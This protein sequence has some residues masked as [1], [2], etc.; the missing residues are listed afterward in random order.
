MP[1]I[2]MNDML[3]H[4]YRYNYAVGAFGVAGWDMLGGVV[5]AAETMRA[6]I[7]LSLSKTYPGTEN[8]EPLA[9]A[10]VSI[11]Q[12]ASIPI[13]FQVEVEDDPNTVAE[14]IKT[15]CGGVVFHAS[16]L[17]FP[18]NVTLTKKAVELADVQ[19][20]VNARTAGFCR[21]IDQA[22]PLI[23][24]DGFNAHAGGF[25][26]HADCHPTTSHG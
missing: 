11:A 5:E 20:A 4:A 1:L 13:A 3:Q 16:Q 24:A 12:R 2:N 22:H 23:M 6:P 26:K 10:V 9:L 21:T 7:I 8:I 14:A 19:V 25:R 18:D 15:G 17:S